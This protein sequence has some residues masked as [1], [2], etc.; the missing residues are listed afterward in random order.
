MKKS[1]CLQGLIRSVYRSTWVGDFETFWSQGGRAGALG[2]RDTKSFQPEDPC[3]ISK[4]I[5]FLYYHPR[6]LQRY[7]VSSE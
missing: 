6:R 7:N 3:T 1:P 5:Y 4:I 2:R